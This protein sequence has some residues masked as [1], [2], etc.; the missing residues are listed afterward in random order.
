VKEKE[1]DQVQAANNRAIAQTNHSYWSLT[2]KKD[3]AIKLTETAVPFTVSVDMPVDLAEAIT[4]YTETTVFDCMTKR[5]EQQINAAAKRLS[6][7]KKDKDGKV[8]ESAKTP[9]QITE[10]FATWLP[11]QNTRTRKIVDPVAEFEAMFE[12]LAS[13]LGGADK[14]DML[15]KQLRQKAAQAAQASAPSA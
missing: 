10:F 13:V 15:I 14:R 3:Y 5:I 6:N 11:N 8:V 12:K 1:K 7:D 2:M 9:E 4:K